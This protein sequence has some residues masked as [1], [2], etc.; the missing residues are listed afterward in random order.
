MPRKP[1][2]YSEQ[3]ARKF[4]RGTGHPSV[5]SAIRAGARTN[6][7]WLAFLDGHIARFWSDNGKRARRRV[8]HRHPVV[9]SEQAAG[10]GP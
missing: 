1:R 2:H 3:A 6:D 4:L 9:V 8:V 5:D 7:Q 10:W